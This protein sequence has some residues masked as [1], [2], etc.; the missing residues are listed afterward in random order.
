[1]LLVALRPRKQIKSLTPL[2]QQQNVATK[3]HP[4]GRRGQ[5]FSRKLI[6]QSVQSSD[7]TPVNLM[8]TAMTSSA[9]GKS[10]PTVKLEGAS[11]ISQTSE[12]SKKQGDQQEPGKLARTSRT[13]LLYKGGKK[14]PNPFLSR[15]RFLRVTPPHP[16]LPSVFGAGPMA[17]RHGRQ[18]MGRLLGDVMQQAAVWC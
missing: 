15:L 8:C 5:T 13:G 14:P 10:K 6:G 7:S 17:A 12:T 2:L 18:P 1:M 4:I 11:E 16:P 3:G 9:P